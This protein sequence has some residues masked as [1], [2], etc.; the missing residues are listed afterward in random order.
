MSE[1]L[2]KQA[3]EKLA[4]A[5]KLIREAGELAKEG[6]FVLHFGEV[7]DFIPSKALDRETYTDRALAELIQ[8]GRYNG[9][10]RVDNGRRYSDGSVQ[11]DYVEKPTTPHSELSEDE[12]E[13]AV[14][15]IIDGIIDNLDIPYESREYGARDRWWHPSR[16]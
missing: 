1:E 2:E 7:G 12:I 6:Q 11:W 4:E 10:D 5:W 14:E 9:E 3:H 15:A 16:C 13:A 8:N